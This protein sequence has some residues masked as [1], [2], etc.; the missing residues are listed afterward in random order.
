MNMLFQS[1]ECTNI[2]PNSVNITEEAVIYEKP[3]NL[4]VNGNQWLTFMCTP[5]NIKELAVGFLFNE[6]KIASKKE[7]ANIHVCNNQDIVDVW[8]HHSVEQPISWKR[9]SGCTGGYSSLEQTKNKPSF[10]PGSP[11]LSTHNIQDLIN[12]FNKSQNLYKVTGGVHAS[13]I[14]DGK[15][16]I[17]VM[18][19]IG[20]HNTLDKLSGFY[21]LEQI[22]AIPL[23]ILSTGRISSEMLLKASQLGTPILISRTSATSLSVEMAADFGITLI[24]YARGNRLT[25]YSHPDRILT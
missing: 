25:V 23:A 13:A 24:G 21:I 20:R 19:D 15:D 17:K 7:I 9:T 1:I 2:R 16:I 5:S 12:K 18:E 4:F 10:Q 22:A 6:D 8:L 11:K 3:V 14:S